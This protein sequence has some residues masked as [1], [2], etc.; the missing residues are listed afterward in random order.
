MIKID[1]IAKK[2]S[3]IVAALAATALCQSLWADET[4]A[5]YEMSYIADQARGSLVANGLYQRAIDGLAGGSHDPLAKY[6]N[7]CV[8]Q[9][10]AG[11]H[12]G[13]RR[14]CNRAVDLSEQAARTAPA[15]LSHEHQRNLA[16]ALS[17]RGVLRAI[18]GQEG[19]EDDFRRAIESPVQLEVAARNLD[20]FNGTN[21]GALAAVDA[22]PA[23]N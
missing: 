12:R 22:A 1:T 11:Q 6:L 16:A 20:R 18:R 7:L 19:A 15:N 10:M 3:L 5:G 23:T 13:A 17:N 8:A 14:S 21:E 4:A 2:P 9:V